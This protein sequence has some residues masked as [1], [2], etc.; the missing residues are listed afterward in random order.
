MKESFRFFIHYLG[1]FMCFFLLTA[2]F[3]YGA[4]TYFPNSLLSIYWISLNLLAI[5]L[6]YSLYLF[7]RSI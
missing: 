3:L 6:I 7:K 2:F 1:R 4:S 5:F